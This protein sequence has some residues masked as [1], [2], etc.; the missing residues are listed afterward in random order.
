MVLKRI[1]RQFLNQHLS[2]NIRPGQKFDRKAKKI[3]QNRNYFRYIPLRKRIGRV[4]SY[5]KN[6][7]IYSLNDKINQVKYKYNKDPIESKYD[8]FFK[9]IE[10]CSTLIKNVEKSST[11][12]KSELCQDESVNN[13]TCKVNKR[14]R[15]RNQWTGL[16]VNW[17]RWPSRLYK[18][19]KSRYYLYTLNQYKVGFA[20][21]YD[22]RD[23]SSIYK[24][25]LM[26]RKKLGL[27]YGNLSKKEIY[28]TIQRAEKFRGVFRENVLRVLESRL[29]VILYR[30]GFFKT[31]PSARQWI[32]HRKILVN[33][34]VV[35]IA[36]YQVK[37]GD[38]ISVDR[39]ERDILKQGIERRFSMMKNLKSYR[40]RR[41]KWPFVGVEDEK[42]LKKI[43]K[44]KSGMLNY[45]KELL[46][47]DTKSRIKKSSKELSLSR[48][49]KRRSNKVLRRSTKFLRR[50][51]RFLRRH[52]NR[53]RFRI[54]KKHIDK[55]Q[56]NRTTLV[57]DKKFVYNKEKFHDGVRQRR[58]KKI[59]SFETKK[60]KPLFVISDT[61]KQD[62]K[63]KQQQKLSDW[64][65]TIKQLIKIKKIARLTSKEYGLKIRDPLFTYKCLMLLKNPASRFFS[66]YTTRRPT[67]RGIKKPLHLEISYQT[68]TAIYLYSPQKV[69][70][71]VNLDIDGI[72]K[73]Y[74]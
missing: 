21:K 27:L 49:R 62:S 59:V 36:H 2:E 64:S 5:L 6:S 55:Q 65:E 25:Q 4:H 7:Q 3:V 66:R 37:A 41:H 68:L 30:I 61:R 50:Y 31:I 42:M 51:N 34:Q 69:F 70:F 63:L 67:F 72:K 54:G 16:D 40:T 18:S 8:P 43:V 15:P 48:R 19:Q 12:Y 71:P 35:T 60:S 53:P 47:K 22:R 13:L 46:F 11:H 58:D 1:I 38:V 44:L 10:R 33:Q 39:V 45:F 29:D 17:L 9:Y 20:R 28:R 26:E 52:N 14:F 24:S 74:Y 73:S 56:T 23:A 57:H 32:I